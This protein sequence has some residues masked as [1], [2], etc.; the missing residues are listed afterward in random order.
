MLNQAGYFDRVTNIQP[1]QKVTIQTTYPKGHAG[2]KV[3]VIVLDG[4]T[5]ENNEKAKILQLDRKR[6]IDFTFQTAGD[7][8]IYRILL[9]KGNDTK[10]VQ[11]WVGPEPLPVKR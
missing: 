5:L 1:L 3:A 11:L 4:G 10:V 8:G 9:R 2:E 7:A 6:G